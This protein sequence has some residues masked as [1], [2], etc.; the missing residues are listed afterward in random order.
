MFLN[1]PHYLILV[2][3]KYSDKFQM[4]SY[5]AQNEIELLLNTPV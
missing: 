4:K 3:N 5:V 2:D 1:Q